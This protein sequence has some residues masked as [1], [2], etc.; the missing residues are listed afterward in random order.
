MRSKEK[1]TPFPDFFL[2][3]NQVLQ[4]NHYQSR[5]EIGTLSETAQYFP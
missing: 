2:Q 1:V 5:L 3:T 4:T